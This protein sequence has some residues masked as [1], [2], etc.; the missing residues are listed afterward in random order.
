M[1]GKRKSP[2]P[3]KRH[4]KPVTNLKT[5]RQHQKREEKRIKELERSL[6]D[7]TLGVYIHIPFCKSKC[8]YCDFYSL[9]GHESRMDAY[10]L[11][12]SA[13]LNELAPSMASYTVDTVYLGGGTP[14]IFGEQRLKNLL[15]LLTKTLHLAKNCEFTME[16]NPDSVTPSLIRTVRKAGVNRISLGMQSAQDNELRA[17]GRPHT[18]E[19]TRKAVQAIR[20][21]K[22]KNLSLD[23]IYGLPGQTM[24]SWQASV[25]EALSLGP[26]HLS[27]Y[28][29]TLEEGTPLWAAR[30]HTPLADDDEQ[31]DRYLWA[32]ERLKTA[33]F[34]QYEISNFAK[35]GFASR[36]NQKYWRGEEYVGFGPAA[37]SDFGGC[38]YS[39]IADLEGYIDGMASG[40]EL[41][42]ESEQIP[43]KERA[44]EYVMLRL[45]TTE[46]ILQEEYHRLFR[47]SFAPLQARLEQY[48]A[49]GWAV[50]E[51]GR[52]HFTPEG[53]L[54]SNPLIGGILEAQEADMVRNSAV[55]LRGTPPADG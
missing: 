1:F 31:A 5:V 25:E 18:M 34:E 47:M 27:L 10:A 36:H 15:N 3:R 38:R 28:A 55:N 11:A 46:G 49:Q 44:R 2:T 22:I 52:W 6:R 12:L 19:Q 40:K 24:E 42:A 16:C 50:C 14:S 23:L 41:V 53:F 54:R 26:E 29:L 21:G 20:K 43:E 17:V 35:P 4:Q 8:A 9:P 39:Y 37:H 51:Q 48:A 13:N 33:G 30:E 32:V 45:R 7:R